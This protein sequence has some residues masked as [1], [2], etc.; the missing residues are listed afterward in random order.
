MTV[1]AAVEFVVGLWF[2]RTAESPKYYHANGN[3]TMALIVLREMYA[4]NTGMSAARYPVKHLI[5]SQST[6]SNRMQ[7]VSS[8]GKTARVLQKIFRDVGN[9]FSPPLLR[10]T[11]LTC[12]IMF[13]N[14][15]G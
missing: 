4:A 6:D 1:L 14:M 12:S 11:M 2:L 9:L 10:I 15:F 5:G 8:K 7:K 13:A 3:T